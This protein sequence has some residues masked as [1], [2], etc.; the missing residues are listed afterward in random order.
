MKV[1]VQVSTCECVWLQ[2]KSN[3][4]SRCAASLKPFLTEHHTAPGAQAASCTLGNHCYVLHTAPV[5]YIPNPT[6]FTAIK[7]WSKNFCEELTT[8]ADK[9]IWVMVLASIS[10]LW[11]I[12]CLLALPSSH[13]DDCCVQSFCTT[14]VQPDCSSLCKGPD[15]RVCFR[16][17]HAFG[18]PGGV[19]FLTQL[20]YCP[21]VCGFQHYTFLASIQQS[22]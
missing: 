14:T 22:T 7:L 3:T 15:K 13:L 9:R 16:E 21:F 17:V 18:Q 2:L 1:D 10:L 20:Q 19:W 6:V 5:T 12:C 8:K 4:C 11:T